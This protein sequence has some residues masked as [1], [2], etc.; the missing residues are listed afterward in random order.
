MGVSGDVPVEAILV[1]LLGFVHFNLEPAAEADDRKLR[2]C[3]LRWKDHREIEFARLRQG[4]TL[5][6]QMPE[7]IAIM[8]FWK[9]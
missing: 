5:A 8:V 4:V 7:H 9:L 3:L 2:C 1:R 6:T